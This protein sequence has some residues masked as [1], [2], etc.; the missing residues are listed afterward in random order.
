MEKLFIK[1]YKNSANNTII[2]YVR[3]KKSTYC[4]RYKK[5]SAKIKPV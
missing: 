4:I 2:Y 1:Q 3:R 5:S